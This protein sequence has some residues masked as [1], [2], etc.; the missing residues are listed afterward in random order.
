MNEVRNKNTKLIKWGDAHG[1]HAIV[2]VNA[3]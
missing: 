1:A 3:T 2:S